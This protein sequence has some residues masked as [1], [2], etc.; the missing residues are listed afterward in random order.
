MSLK[1]V[2]HLSKQDVLIVMGTQDHLVPMEQAW[3]SAKAM[4]N[5]RSMSVRI[6]T[7]QEQG[8]EHCQIGNPRL[9][10]DEILSWLQRLEHRD[11]ALKDPLPYLATGS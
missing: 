2:A 6:I 10:I 9:T 1:D 11:Q 4:S 8:A 5:A 7:E 3:I